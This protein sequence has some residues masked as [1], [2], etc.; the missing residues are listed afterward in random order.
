[1]SPKF[2]VY[3]IW[4]IWVISWTAAVFWSAPVIK[5]AGF[6]GQLPYRLI[7]LAGVLLLFGVWSP[8]M[9]AMTQLWHPGP[10]VMWTLDLVIILG[11][12]FSWWARCIWEFCGRP[13]SPANRITS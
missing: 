5:R 11:F 4:V 12:A 9:M 1:M 8:R 3:L 10:R 13:A 2:A 7:T 6:G